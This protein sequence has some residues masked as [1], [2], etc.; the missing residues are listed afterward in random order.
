MATIVSRKLHKP[1]VFMSKENASVA[2]G[3]VMNFL[4]P[5]KDCLHKFHQSTV[6]T[7]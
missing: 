6:Y 5:D 3:F 2:E 7:G 4:G 1:P